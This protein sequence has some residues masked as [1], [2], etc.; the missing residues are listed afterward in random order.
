MG[1]QA[2]GA[3]S[4][5]F[6][7]PFLALFAASTSHILYEGLGLQKRK[8]A[9]L[10]KGRTILGAELLASLIS[11]ADSGLFGHPYLALFA[12]SKAHFQFGIGP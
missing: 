9:R 1:S 5:L 8:K 10:K 7:H 12:A 3:D 4:G 2:W 6:G 11:G